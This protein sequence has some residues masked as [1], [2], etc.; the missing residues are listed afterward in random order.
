MSAKSRYIPLSDLLFAQVFD[1][2]SNEKALFSKI[3][4]TLF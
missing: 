2:S 1:L 3:W 4:T